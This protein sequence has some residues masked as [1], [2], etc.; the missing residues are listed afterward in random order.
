MADDS[1][2]KLY[3]TTLQ[4]IGAVSKLPMVHVERE[5]FLR[6]QFA[7]SPHLAVVLESGP[8][9]VYTVESLRQ[10]A[11]SIIKN[12]TAKTSMASFATGLPGNPVVMIAAGGA[13]VAQYFGFAINLAQQ[14]A[15]LFG[16]DDLFDDGGQLSEAAQIRVI[17]YLGA[18]FGAAGAAALVSQ[19]SKLAGA[20]LGKKVAAQALTKTAWYPLVKKVGALVGKQVT[21]KS[22]EKTITKAVP[23]AGG[24]IA[25]GLTFMTFR[26]MGNRLADT[27]AANLNGDFDEE[28][29]LNPDFAASVETSTVV[30]EQIR[31]GAS[32]RET[33]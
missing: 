20:N 23:V 30:V 27:L 26:P 31:D 4:T 15:Y 24:V 2:D 11:N 28:L 9:A 13:D 6:K 5:A 8:Q 3:A 14:L 22:V 17:A 10:K 7:S 25:G 16:E 12:S 18:M 19:T 33:E 1:Q 32:E 29:E 21:K